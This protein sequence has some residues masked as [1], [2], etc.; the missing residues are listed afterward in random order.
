MPDE[1]T[2][3]V[4]E[5][6]TPAYRETLKFNKWLECFLDKNNKLTYGNATQSAIL[7]YNLDP[8]TQYGSACQIAHDN[9]RKHKHLALMY[10]ETKMVNTGKDEQGN[11]IETLFGLGMM[12]DVAIARMLQSKYP[13]WWDRV[14][15]L[16]GFAEPKGGVTN[17][18]QVNTYEALT[19]EE[20][21]ER[22]KQLITAEQNRTDT[23]DAGIREPQE[24]GPAEVRQDALKAMGSGYGDQT[25]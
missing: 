23:G 22:A 4:Q 17:N 19:D 1:T 15:E 11:K 13:D 6:Q 12:L 10:A 20:L 21:I 2:P 16:C 9:I 24:A 25:H 14:M 8:K 3:A 7:A 18:I 5:K